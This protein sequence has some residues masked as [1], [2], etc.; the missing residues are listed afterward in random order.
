MKITDKIC[1]SKGSSDM[2]KQIQSKNEWFEAGKNY[3]I[4]LLDEEIIFRKTPFYSNKGY[5]ATKKT[6]GWVSFKY[7]DFENILPIGHFALA[8][9]SDEDMLVFNIKNNL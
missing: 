6:N 5:K 3:L 9:D 8:D 2:N 4:I 7:T 1:I